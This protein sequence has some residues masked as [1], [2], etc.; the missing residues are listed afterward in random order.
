MKTAL[1]QLLISMLILGTLQMRRRLPLTV[2]TLLSITCG[3]FGL[4][5]VVRIAAQGIAHPPKWDFLCFWLYA[6]VAAT[7]HNVYDPVNFEAF[8][9]NVPHDNEFSREVLNVGMPY[10]PPTILLFYPLAFFDNIKSAVTFWYILNITALFALT[11]VLWRAFFSEHGK[12]ALPAVFG[13]VT[14][15]TPTLTNLEFAQTLIFVVLFST[16]F[17]TDQLPERKGL[18]LAIA[19][20]VKPI[21]LVFLLYPLIRRQ[22]RLVAAC[23]MT[24]CLSVLAA[25]LCLSRQ[26]IVS[27]FVNNPVKREP[28]YLFGSF[29]AEDL[30]QSL[31]SLLLKYQHLFG[32]HANTIYVI[33]ALL[34]L[35]VS[36]AICL[37]IGEADGDLSVAVLAPLGL[38]IYPA[39]S[40]FYG[41]L[42]L[43]PLTVLWHK[44]EH[45]LGGSIAV[46]LLWG[47]EITLL[48]FGWSSKTGFVGFMIFWI[49]AALNLCRCEGKRAKPG[50]ITS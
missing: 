10:P 13:L 44:R 5:F 23:F 47:A 49:F 37:R 15:F 34:M 24:L 41:A 11:W 9:G 42:L 50:K 33:A 8:A 39:T 14:C 7:T 25:L 20:I 45:V 2:R 46:M 32:G 6:H 38:M 19:I 16:L 31:L 35:I 43:L 26:A 28:Q 21:A 3:L 40:V 36:V 12:S 27:Y 17:I 1:A 18:W 22:V 29:A 30:N 4:I 48:S